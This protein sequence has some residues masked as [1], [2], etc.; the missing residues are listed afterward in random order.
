MLA[1]YRCTLATGRSFWSFTNTRLI[2]CGG[3][4]L[5]SG[6]QPAA[7]QVQADATPETLAFFESKIRPL[8]IEHCFECHS[9]DGEKLQAEL[10]LDNRA[11]LISGGESGATILP[12]SPGESLLIEALRYESFEMPPSGKLPDEQIADF[13]KWISDGAVWPIEAV[14]ED[15]RPQFDLQARAQE[16]WAWRPIVD[17]PIPTVADNAW[18]AD[19]IDNFVLAKL[20]ASE[21]SP[22]TLADKNTLLRRMYFD[23]IGLPPSPAEVAA[24]VDDQSDHAVEK[25]IDQLLASK[26]FGERWGRHWLDL[27]R[28]AES[29]GH[30][31]DEDARNAFQYRDYVIRALNADVPYDQFVREHIAGDLLESPRLHPTDGSNESVLGTGF[32]FLG[33]WVHS[34][35]DI[36]KDESDRFDNMIDVMSKTFL[37]VTVACARCHDHKFDAIS[38]ADYYSL[39]GFLQSSDFRH[40]RYESVEHNRGIAAK[41]AEQTDRFRTRIAKL[42]KLPS[43][44]K[45]LRSLDNRDTLAAQGA[46]VCVDYTGLFANADNDWMQDGF[47]FG[48][49]P[50][51]IGDAFVTQSGK[52]VLNDWP[53]AVADPFW[54]DL[55][56][57]NEPETNL[58]DKLASI[59]S[60]GRT[61]ITPTFEVVD[62]SVHCYVQGSGHIFAAV[63]SHRLVAGPLHAETIVK[64][65]PR[66]EG[67]RQDQ[68][69]SLKLDR[70]VGHHVHLEFVPAAENDLSVSLVA[71]GDIAKLRKAIAAAREQLASKIAT[72]QTQ[73]GSLSTSDTPD[74]K[75]LDRIVR[76]WNESRDDLRKSVRWESHLAMAMRDGSPEDDRILIRGSSSNPGEIVAR[77]ILTALRSSEAPELQRTTRSGRLAL[78][79]QINARE[80]PLSSR[81]IVN[82]IWHH[83]IGTGIVPTTDD[84]GV[85]GQRP[86][87]PMLLDHLAHRFL[88]GDRS[89]KRLIK[90]IMLSQTYQMSGL[91]DPVAAELDPKNT[92][93][94][95][96]KPRRLEGEI[97]RDSLLAISGQLDYQQFGPPVPIHLTQFMQGRGR[98]AKSGPLDGDNRRTIYVAV[99]RNFL[100]PFSLAFDT[101]VPFS[102]MGRRTSSNV[103][104]QSL[105]LLNDPLVHNL[106]SE[107]ASKIVSE[108]DALGDQIRALYIA[109]FA[110]EPTQAEL[111]VATNFL[112]TPTSSSDQPAE[113]RMKS[114]AHALIN[115]KEFIFV[116]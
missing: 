53:A 10:R 46:Q 113:D 91:V 20:E 104:A 40:V 8:L 18:P 107:W 13:E 82:R 58:R 96:H 24:F 81:V 115:A 90:T 5:F 1:T 38:T 116:R 80:N 19:P 89:I 85:L 6:T 23:L 87:H 106:A 32:W 2:L 34:P 77:Q 7:A 64:I 99:R 26:H 36:R 28:Y 70:Y 39:S 97:I 93:Q 3:L 84:F 73:L 61:L 31:F 43:S 59:N 105:I 51:A 60:S 88:R 112:T 57:T 54:T 102:T 35:V 33:E 52:V 63:D 37:G 109:A 71:Q 48:H 103:P 110:R 101:P 111:A 50:A 55:K 68:W 100:S 67:K 76:R 75:K 15:S 95:H 114:F 44:E 16:H 69:I 74:S 65:K 62:G 56:S 30:E 11:S 4:L 72:H 94:H 79:E 27:V 25:A 12:G 66:P 41:L 83:L 98:P 108:H 42:A 49:R 78:A 22:A 9:A 17:Y 86:S 14:K 92:L 47:T 29:R 45:L 21:L